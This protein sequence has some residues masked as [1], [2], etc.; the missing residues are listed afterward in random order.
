MSTAE[1]KIDVISRI[2]NIEESVIIEEI[3]N[4]LDFELSNE[5]FQ[6][7]PQQKERVNEAKTEY[8]AGKVLSEK[9][10]DDAI[11]QWLNEK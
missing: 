10:A 1:L 9:Q 5:S 8:L 11:E 2:A 3:R 7:T 6:L 4:L